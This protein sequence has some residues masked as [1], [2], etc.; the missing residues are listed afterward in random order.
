MR[1]WPKERAGS[2]R[3]T[4]APHPKSPKAANNNEPGDLKHLPTSRP[5]RWPSRLAL[6]TSS[7]QM[8]SRAQGKAQVGTEN[9]PK[10]LQGRER[11]RTGGRKRGSRSAYSPAQPPHS[12]PSAVRC[13]C[14]HSCRHGAWRPA[15][16]P[17]GCTWQPAVLPHDP[18]SQPATPSPLR[19][20]FASVRRLGG[21]QSAPTRR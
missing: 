11:R 12:E 9:R 13:T 3:L 5:V 6:G 14:Q 16:C 10:M 18:P 20:A 7:C 21:C 15:K 4:C 19:L 2:H 8:T 17:V 1:L